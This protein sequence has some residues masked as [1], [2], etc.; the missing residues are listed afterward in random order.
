MSSLFCLK[1]AHEASVLLQGRPWLR[2][3]TGATWAGRGARLVR[4]RGGG[5]HVRFG[6][7]SSGGRSG[8]R[9]GV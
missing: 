8:E 5:R 9:G 3:W 6:C 7:G 2:G 1:V 4:Q